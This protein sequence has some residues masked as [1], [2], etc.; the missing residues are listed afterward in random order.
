MGKKS[1]IEREEK[2]D[3]YATLRTKDKRK[4]TLI[5]IAVLSGIAAV[6]VV[7]A[8][9][10]TN[11]T[12]SAP[13]APPGAGKLGD[14]H[15]HASILVK[16]FGD[17]FDFS[18]PAYQ[19]KSSWIHF[20]AKDGNT[21]H[22][23]SSGVTLGYLFK[24]IKIGLDDKCFIFPDARKFCT[25]EDYSLKFYFNHAPVPSIT[26]LV[27]HNEDRILVSYGNENQTQIDAQLTELDSQPILN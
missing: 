19:V 11:L 1:R 3:S 9:N 2:R 25:N 4:H 7:S 15:E 18:L 6:V 22:R 24:T 5:A 12:Q 27:I 10:F 14:E 17:K 21:V 23:H 26:D 16:I 13:G 20:E 8:Y